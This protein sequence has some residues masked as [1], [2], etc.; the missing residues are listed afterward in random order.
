MKNGHLFGHFVCNVSTLYRTYVYLCLSHLIV[1]S[2]I[3]VL[4]YLMYWMC[5]WAY[6]V[7]T[8]M[9][10]RMC[11]EWTNIVQ[12]MKSTLKQ[13]LSYWH[14]S[15]S[16]NIGIAFIPLRIFKLNN[17]QFLNYSESAHFYPFLFVSRSILSQSSFHWKENTLCPHSNKSD[18]GFFFF[19]LR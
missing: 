15:S 11:I 7:A 4:C 1:S 10:I 2:C 5:E 18:F 6:A 3:R 8:I 9:H 14:I 16:G 13:T 12:I 19:F 17:W